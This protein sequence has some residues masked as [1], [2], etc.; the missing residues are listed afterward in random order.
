MLRFSRVFADFGQFGQGVVCVFNG[1]PD[2]GPRF[3][4]S[5]AAA[6]AEFARR[7]AMCPIA[8]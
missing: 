3:L 8:L 4:R 7:S 1:L 5:C 2:F 6:G